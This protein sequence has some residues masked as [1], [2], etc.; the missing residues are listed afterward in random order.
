MENHSSTR[1]VELIAWK[2]TSHKD[3][4]EVCLPNSRLLS[5]LYGMLSSMTISLVFISGKPQNQGAYPNPSVADNFCVTFFL[6]V[7]V[8][9]HSFMLLRIL[10]IILQG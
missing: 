1:Q 7:T 6:Q 5:G 9:F 3:H 2:T 8:L 4:L 10:H